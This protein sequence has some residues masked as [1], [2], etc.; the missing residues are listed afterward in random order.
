LKTIKQV[1]VIPV[2]L[3]G[4][5]PAPAWDK[6]E[7][8]HV[9]ISEHFGVALHR[10][11]CGCGVE[12]VMPLDCIIDGKDLGWHMIK[13]SNGTISFTPSI[14]NYQFPC[15]SHYIITKNIANFV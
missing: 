12:T 6:M 7:E 2:F 9:Y 11:L 8:H 13:E 1:E 5:S 14:A 3:E 15:K 10:C 4:D